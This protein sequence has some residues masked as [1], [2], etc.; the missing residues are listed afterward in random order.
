VVAVAKLPGRERSMDSPMR[1]SKRACASES[2][3]THI[4]TNRKGRCGCF[5]TKSSSRVVYV[6]RGTLVFWTV[7]LIGSVCWVPHLC[8][9]LIEGHVGT[10]V[11]NPV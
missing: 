6:L 8:V 4:R 10:W 2:C 3:D 11:L 5:E 7:L 1:K 9:L